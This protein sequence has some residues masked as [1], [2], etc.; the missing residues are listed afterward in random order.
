VQLFLFLN[1]FVG[2]VDGVEVIIGE[3]TQMDAVEFSKE[4]LKPIAKFGFY[5]F[6]NFKK[7]H[8]QLGVVVNDLVL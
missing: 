2:G 1:F 6:S 3:I 4:N 8:W 5:F 7:I